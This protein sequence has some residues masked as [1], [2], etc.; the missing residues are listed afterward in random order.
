MND[1]ERMTVAEALREVTQRLSLISDTARLDAELLMAHALGTDR[2]QMLLRYMA[3][4]APVELATLV[5]R[6]AHREPIA[7]IL[8]DAEFYGRAFIV[9]PDVLIPRS[10]SESVVE[11]ALEVAPDS[12]RVLD[13]GTGSGAL[14]ITLLAERPALEGVGIDASLGALSVAAANAGRLG[15]ANR[16]HMLRANWHEPGW[17]DELGQ[18]DLIIANPP[19]VETGARLDPDVREFE[20]AGALFSGEQGLDDYRAIIPQLRQLLT[21]TGVVVLEIGS[22][23]SE[24]VTKIAEENGF[25]AELRR[26]LAGR[27]R[28]LIL[29]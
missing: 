28:G 8:G 27:A 25:S 1:W 2:S 7:Y 29:R 22:S 13:M 17:A 3:D 19:Y 5:D 12:G 21:G 15:V 14:L 10:D 6:R 9:T 16:T 26:D 24:Q 20:P 23:Q 11:A 4:D 18:F